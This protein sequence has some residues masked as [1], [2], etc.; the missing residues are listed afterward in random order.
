MTTDAELAVAM[1]EYRR[2]T[3]LKVRAPWDYKRAAA[4][5]T[6]KRGEL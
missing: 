6:G 1:D 3:F 5:P 4:T 2:G